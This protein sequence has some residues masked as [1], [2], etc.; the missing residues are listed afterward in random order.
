MSSYTVKR[1]E[2]YLTQNKHSLHVSLSL[3]LFSLLGGRET[4]DMGEEIRDGPSFV[5]L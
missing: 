5:P 4:E 1:L 2:Q 3:L